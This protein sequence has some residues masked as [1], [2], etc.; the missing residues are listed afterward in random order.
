MQTSNHPQESFLESLGAGIAVFI[1]I[2]FLIFWGSHMEEKYYRSDRNYTTVETLLE[3]EKRMD[4]GDSA[5]EVAEALG[6]HNSSVHYHYRMIKSGTHPRINREN[7][8]RG[9]FQPFNMP[10]VP[11][12]STN[13]K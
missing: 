6:L 13:Y 12:R 2:F 9:G 4:R 1:F 11:D 3:L 8:P 5:N 10:D 7:P